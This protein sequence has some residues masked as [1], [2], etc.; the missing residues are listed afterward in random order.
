MANQL[1]FRI[2][3]SGFC[4][5]TFLNC[6]ATAYA[7][8]QSPE[9]TER[10][11][12][13][14]IH[15][16]GNR[17]T[18][19]ST[20]CGVAQSGVT[21]AIFQARYF[22]LYD[23]MSGHSSQRCLFDGT[24]TEAEKRINESNFYDCGSAETI[25]F[26]FGFAGY[27]YEHISD[28]AR[29]HASIAAAIDSGMPVLARLIG[30]EDPW[31]V[32]SGYEGDTL[33][34]PDH[35]NAQRKPAAAPGTEEIAS[36]Y[37]FGAKIQPRYTLKDGLERIIRVMEENAAAGVWQSYIDKI[38]L[39]VV[40]GNLALEN[41][42]RAIRMKRVAETMWHTFNCHNFAEVFRSRDLVELRRAEFDALCKEIGTSCYG[43]THDLAWAL[44][45]LEAQIDWTKHSAHFCCEMAELTLRQIAQNDARVLEIIK[46]MQAI[47]AKG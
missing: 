47:L 19:C 2:P 25:D 26:L 18:G 33:I 6:F 1:D 29:F 35:A 11:G 41:E 16:A 36:L 42:E 13:M 46:E 8:L 44:I 20:D 3:F 23:A 12:L 34:I 9:L 5:T 30:G 27:A 7:F 10:E 24:L 38:G 32:L 40:E 43:Y 28:P 21:P 39:Y 4:S 31:R 15:H 37:L 45:H 22:F 17:C 14:C